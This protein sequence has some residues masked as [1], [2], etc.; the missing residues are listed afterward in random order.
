MT[1]NVSAC[2]SCG[3]SAPASGPWPAKQAADAHNAVCPRQRPKR[4]KPER[5]YP[6]AECVDTPPEGVGDSS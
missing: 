6:A 3:W 4:P 2:P 1:T 5:I